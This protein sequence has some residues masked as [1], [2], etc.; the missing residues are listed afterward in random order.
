MS[1]TKSASLKNMALLMIVERSH[2]R[3]MLKLTQVAHG[4]L[5]GISFGK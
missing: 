1:R 5:I 2:Y 3:W 4:L